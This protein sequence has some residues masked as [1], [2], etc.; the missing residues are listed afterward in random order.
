MPKREEDPRIPAFSPCQ[1]CLKFSQRLLKGF[2]CWFKTRFNVMPFFSCSLV[3]LPFCIRRP[4]AASYVFW[5]FSFIFTARFVVRCGHCRISCKVHRCG[6]C[7]TCVVHLVD[8]LFPFLLFFPRLLSVLCCWGSRILC[9]RS[10]RGRLNVTHGD[11]FLFYPFV[12]IRRA[13]RVL[14]GFDHF[15]VFVWFACSRLMSHL[16]RKNA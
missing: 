15:V 16:R 1:R 14:V 7:F 12:C 2:V 3:G 9:L 11:L 8:M 5:V 6:K 13:A 4:V 10:Y